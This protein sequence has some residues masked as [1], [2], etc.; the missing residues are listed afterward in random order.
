MDDYISLSMLNDYIFCPYSIYL[1]NVYANTDEEVYHAYPQ[2]LGK[3]AHL[4]IDKKIPE[5]KGIITSLPVLSNE[6]RIQGIID[7][8]RVHDK[9]LIERK[10]QLK[11]IYKGHLYQ[12]WGEYLCMNEMGYIVENLAFY[13]TAHNRMIPIP[14][15]QDKEKEEIHRLLDEIRNFDIEQSIPINENKCKHCIYS[16]LCDKIEIENVYD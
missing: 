16:R 10:H 4:S 7:E 8:F 14:L 3:Q 12:L 11:K 15:P 1:H 2:I 13:E 6:F 5:R 9:L